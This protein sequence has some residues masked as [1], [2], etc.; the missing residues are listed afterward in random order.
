MLDYYKKFL[1]NNIS[2]Q[3]IYNGTLSKK[4]KKADK[5]RC[6]FVVV[7]GEDE[8][9]KGVLQLKNPKLRPTTIKF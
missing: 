6:K 8:I 9:E 1:K 7:L 2:A 5:L 4:F 3:I